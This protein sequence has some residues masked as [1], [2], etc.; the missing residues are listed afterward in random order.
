MTDQKVQLFEDVKKAVYDDSY[1]WIVLWGPPRSSKTTMAGWILYSLYKDWHKMLSAFGYNLSQILYKMNNGIPERWPTVNGLHMR[2]PALNWDDFGAYSNKA[3]TQYDE[4]WDHFKGGFDVLGTKIGVLVATMVDPLEPTFQIQSKYTHEIQILDKGVYKYDRVE[5]RQDF[6]GWKPKAKKIFVEKNTFD[7]WPDWV[8]KEYDAIRMELAEEVMQRIEDSMAINHTE[9][10]LKVCKTID[11]ELMKLIDQRGPICYDR[12]DDVGKEGRQALVRLKARGLAIP[13]QIQGNYYKYDLTALGRNVLSLHLN[14][15]LQHASSPYR[16]PSDIAVRAIPQ[17]TIAGFQTKKE[18]AEALRFQGL[19]VTE[20][21]DKNDPD[22]VVWKDELNPSEVIAVKSLVTAKVVDVNAECLKEIEFAKKHSMDKIRLICLSSLSKKKMFD[23][24][25]NFQDKIACEDQ[26]APKP[27]AQT[28]P[29]AVK[30]AQEE[31]DASGKKNQV[32]L[33]LRL[34]TSPVTVT[35]R[36]AAVSDAFGVG[37]DDQK[38]F[39]I[40]DNVALKY[41]DNDLIYVTGDSGSGK[42]TFLKLFADHIQQR[43]LTYASFENMKPSEDEGVINSIGSSKE[44][45]FALLATAGLSEAFLM[46]RKYKELSEGQK[47]R[48]RLA[49][50]I[51]TEA[52]VLLIDEFGATLDREMAKVLAYCVQKWARRNNKMLVIA[53]THKDLIEDFNPNIVI[54]KKFGQTT[55]IKYFSGAPR[56]FSLINQMKIE[57]ATK[58]DYEHLKMFHYL[59]GRPVAVKA[60]FR[61]VHGSEVIGIIVYTLSFRALRYR[62]QIFPEYKNNIQK[63]N[64]EILRISRVIIH[65]K[66][67]G[68]G[69]ASELVRQTLQL[70]NARLVETVAAMARYNPFFEKAGMTLVGKMALQK[71]QIDL[72][73]FLDRTGGKLSLLHNKPLCKAYINSLDRMQFQELCKNLERS[74]SSVGA[75]SPGRMDELKRKLSEGNVIDVLMNLLPVERVYLYWLNPVWQAQTRTPTQLLQDSNLDRGPP[76]VS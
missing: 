25:V 52:R 33:D 19:R 50:L 74:V 9:A 67:R 1:M 41:D 44:E 45:A 76:I 66:Y 57:A 68:I 11:F 73:Q 37:I 6:H 40:F 53:T 59:A 13:I 72:L 2:V 43:G 16:Q 49:K 20:S 15:A 3:V 4:A 63:V 75:A 64:A 24:L 35:E 62:N 8:Y 32:I 5:W 39:T 60:A 34:G 27:F 10:M 47:Y 31:I 42:S 29:Q 61:L 18:I 12:I 46:L 23:G 54:D 51:C 17:Q 36:V 69:L 38:E 56:Q 71:D 48:Y 7:R 26:E 55:E 30:T 21:Y 28:Q 70:V 22:L 65:P 14:P 58:D